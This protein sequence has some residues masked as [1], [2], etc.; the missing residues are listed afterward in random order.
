MCSVQIYYL[1]IWLDS[2]FSISPSLRFSL[3]H[4]LSF[5]L[6]LSTLS[7]PLSLLLRA[8]LFSLHLATNILILLFC[9]LLYFYFYFL[10]YQRITS[11]K[12]CENIYFHL[13]IYRILDDLFFMNG[14]NSRRKN[15]LSNSS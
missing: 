11:A 5:S 15:L 1:A 3:L 8:S 6:S 14:K 13:L 9:L 10:L 2:N 4:F 7:L 12:Q